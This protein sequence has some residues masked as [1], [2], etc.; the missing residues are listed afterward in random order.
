MGMKHAFFL[1]TES[2]AMEAEAFLLIMVSNARPFASLVAIARVKLYLVRN[3][4]ERVG[5]PWFSAKT[6][7]TAVS[8]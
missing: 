7:V 6:A 5:I 4:D 3:C 2:G 8:V 1:S